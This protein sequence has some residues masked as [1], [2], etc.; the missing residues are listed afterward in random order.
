MYVG[1]VWNKEKSY[2]ETNR[3]EKRADR[4]QHEGR[5]EHVLPIRS[6]KD[7]ALCLRSCLTPAETGQ[8]I[9]GGMR[10]WRSHT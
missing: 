5:N 4:W 7:H 6:R 3:L 2:E 8:F 9:S 10:K 1:C